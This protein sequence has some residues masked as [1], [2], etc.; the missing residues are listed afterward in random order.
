MKAGDAD[1][2]CRGDGKVGPEGVRLGVL[3][4]NLDLRAEIEIG[5]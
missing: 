2:E 4:S 3:F 1:L 5:R